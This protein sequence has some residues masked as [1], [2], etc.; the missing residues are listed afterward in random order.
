MNRAKFFIVCREKG[1]EQ[2]LE[3]PDTTIR[4]RI[5]SSAKSKFVNHYTTQGALFK[6][7]LSSDS[8]AQTPGQALCALFKTA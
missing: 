1:G 6:Y 2:V 8:V 3:L 4:Q 7:Q 5:L